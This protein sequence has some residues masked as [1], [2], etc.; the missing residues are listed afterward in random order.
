MV[1][2]VGIIDSRRFEA[3]LMQP[4]FHRQ[5]AGVS[6]MPAT[7]SYVHF[8]IIIYLLLS[9]TRQVSAI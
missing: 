2:I 1:V 4:S 7:I 8:K 3:P 9:G 6:G 5:N